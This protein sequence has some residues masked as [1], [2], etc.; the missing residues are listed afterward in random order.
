MSKSFSD[1][2]LQAYLDEALNNTSMAEIEKCLREDEVLREQLVAV[3]Q[4]REAGVH[5][6]GEIWRRHRASC[7]TREQLGGYLLGAMDT[8]QSDYIRFHLEVIQCR[9]C[10]ANLEDLQ[11]QNRE[12]QSVAQSRRRKYFQ[13]SAGYLSKR[14]EKKK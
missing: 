6:L 7:P 11:R 1:Q 12:N 5:G 4:K 3:A 14:Q 13:T 10:I 9:F 2:Q 8:A